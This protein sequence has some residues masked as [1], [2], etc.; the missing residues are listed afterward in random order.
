MT[1]VAAHLGEL[2]E[3]VVDLLGQLAEAPVRAVDVGAH[4]LPIEDVGPRIGERDVLVLRSVVS[5][6]YQVVQNACGE[7][8]PL[9]VC[10]LEFELESLLVEAVVD[11]EVV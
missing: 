5:E 10:N 2:L 6:A 8:A 3:A 7:S 9:R 11:V 4:V 1:S